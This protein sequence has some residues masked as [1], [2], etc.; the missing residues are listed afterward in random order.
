MRAG[1]YH[2]RRD[3]RVEERDERAVGANDVRID[4]E[5][6]GICGTDLVEYADGP[7][8]IPDSEPHSLTGGSLPITMGHE[9]S[10]V[11]SEVGDA[12]TDVTV[13]DCVAVNPLVACEDCAYCDRGKHNLCEH[14]GSIG[15]SAGVDGGFAERAVVESGHVVPLPDSLPCGLGATIEPFCVGLHAVRRSGLRT[16]DTVAVFGAGPIGHSVVQAAW[17]AGAKRV[18]VSE[19]RESRR[20]RALEGGADAVFDPANASPDE[21][22]RE[23]TGGG[24]DRAF[25]VAGTEQTF[26]QALRS[27]KR[28]GT[29]TAISLFKDDIEVTPND[30]VAGERTIVGS[31]GYDAGPLARVEWDMVV[32]KLVSGEFDPES[33]VSARIPLERIV[34]DGFEALLDENT[35][36]VK[37]LV[38]P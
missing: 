2:G 13:G 32:Q 36:H 3:I 23:R 34:E 12:V 38:T 31:L 28:D 37:I 18:F 29:V 8:R 17:S 4:V 5:A 26:T 11:V 6:C 27:T 33:L 24:A 10:G 22:I 25:E 19:P 20:R 30:I 21:E 35:D 15:L 7:V 9:F 1:V 14:A 16:G